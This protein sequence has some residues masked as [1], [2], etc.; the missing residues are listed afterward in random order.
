MGITLG[1]GKVNMI[2][3]VVLY[4]LSS[5]QIFMNINSN[6]TKLAQILLRTEFS[7]LKLIMPHC[8]T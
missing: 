3:T 5:V 6:E 1:R 7:K 4:F 8:G 2:L